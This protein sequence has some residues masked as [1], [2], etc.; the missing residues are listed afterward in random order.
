MPLL[1]I[2]MVEGRNLE[3]KRGISKVL[4]KEISRVVNVPEQRV[5]I[6]FMDVKAE[7]V[8]DGGMHLCDQSKIGV[9]DMTFIKMYLVGEKTVEQKTEMARVVTKEVASIGNIDEK[10]IKM[11]FIDIK[12]DGVS[13]GGILN[14]RDG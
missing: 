6:Y 1:E 12:L 2:H 4:T 7:D 5:K 8:V 13:N 9:G 14:R 11:Y 3:Q 10:A